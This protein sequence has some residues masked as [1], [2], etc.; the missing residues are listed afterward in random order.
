VLK[1][2]KAVKAGPFALMEFSQSAKRT[3]Q[4]R[5]Q[6]SPPAKKEKKWMAGWTKRTNSYAVSI[7]GSVAIPLSIE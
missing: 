6:N 1:N 5:I 7:L 4:R 3:L 2:M